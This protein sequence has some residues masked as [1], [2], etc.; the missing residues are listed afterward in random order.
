MNNV[1]PIEL[2]WTLWALL[3][4]MMAALV[5]GG[6]IMLLIGRYQDARNGAVRLL[7]WQFVIVSGLCW[8][9]LAAM[10]AIGVLALMLPP[11]VDDLATEFERSVA[12]LAAW[13]SPTLLFIVASCFVI[14]AATFLRTEFRLSA[15]YR[16]EM[17]HWTPTN[18]PNRR[19]TDQPPP[20]PDGGEVQ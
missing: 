11:R 2:A 3:G 16:D 17:A 8:L 15:Y 13:L 18:H 12:G 20:E 7:A 14:V 6:A 1:A 10:V 5:F 4:W 9:G 19:A